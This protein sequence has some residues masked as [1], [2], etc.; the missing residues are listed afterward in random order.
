VGK[1]TQLFFM[2]NIM[3]CALLPQMNPDNWQL[4]AVFAQMEVRISLLPYS[5]CTSVSVTIIQNGVEFS[6]NPER[7]LGLVVTNGQT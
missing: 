4:L 3:C 2:A 1:T 5:T 7:K 6:A